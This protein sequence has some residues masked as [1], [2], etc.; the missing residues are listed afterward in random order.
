MRSSFDITL[1]EI[2]YAYSDW[3][4]LTEIKVDPVIIEYAKTHSKRDCFLYNNR[5]YSMYLNPSQKRKD[6]YD[7]NWKFIKSLPE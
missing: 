7:A 6:E 2:K 4:K 1:A 3:N 5:I